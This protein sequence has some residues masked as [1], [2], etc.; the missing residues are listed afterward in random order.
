MKNEE[1]GMRNLVCVVRGLLFLLIIIFSC[2]GVSAQTINLEQARTLALAN[3]RSLA[4]HEMAIR[5]SILDERNQLY[6]MLPQISAGYS[7]TINIFQDWEFVNPFEAI[8][9]G[10][11]FSVTQIIF[12]GGKNFIQRAIAAISTESVRIDAMAEYFKV[13]DSVDNAYYAVLEAAAALEAEE[14]SLQAAVLGLSIAEIRHSSGM[15]NQGDYLK[16]LADK[17]TRENSRNQSRRNLTMSMTRL[18][19]LIGVTEPVE[20][21]QI[22]FNNYDEVIL[23]LA[24]ISD[25]EIIK[26]FEEF[27]NIVVVSNPSLAKAAL[28]NRRAELNLSNTRRDYV[29]TISATIFSTDM[30]FLPSFNA[31]GRSGVSIRGN[32]PVDFWVLNNRIERSTIARDL[33]VLDYAGAQNTLELDLQNELL[34]TISQAGSVLSSRRSL[35]YTERHFEFVMERYRLLQSS[36]SD[37]NEATTLLINSR[38]S[39]NRASYSFLRSLSN[40]RSL[41]AL[42]DKE[43]LIRIL[44]N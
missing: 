21:E 18:R 3:S 29:P 38:N 42:D 8:S 40:L 24:A 13:L 31:T 35:E 6:S 11:N 25:E 16:A 9:A 23:R 43:R 20:L 5:T 15:I 12:Q 27:W 7:A 19:N 33:A 36:V 32:I 39:L 10:A 30:S 4:R 44:L 28:G 26:L 14:S 2:L 41:C 22:V 34:N 1:L 17:E 37:L